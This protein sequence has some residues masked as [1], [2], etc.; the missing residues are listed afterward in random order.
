ME[1][2]LHNKLKDPTSAPAFDHS[3]N[4]RCEP[5]RA[6]NSAAKKLLY[7][8]HYSVERSVDIDLDQVN[9]ELEIANHGKWASYNNDVKGK[10]GAGLSTYWNARMLRNF[11][12]DSEFGFGETLDYM[13]Q[14]GRENEVV[15][16]LVPPSSLTQTPLFDEVP[17]LVSLVER[18]VTIDMCDRIMISR[19]EHNQRINWHS[20]NYYE[21]TYSHAY[22]H[23]PL[24]TNVG[25]EML[26]YMDDKIH[27]QHYGV[28]EAWII[29]TQHNHAV[30]NK[31]NSEDRYHILVLANFE[32]KKFNEL[33]LD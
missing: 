4:P 10:R 25:T 14:I 13:E 26:V 1:V 12:P 11:V 27:R 32:D 21:K 22:L 16:G 23:I 29:N 7:V 17:Y 15:N 33:L 9:K 30:N 5:S 2:T 20:H 19:I 3:C 8:P 6:T 31:I 18:F 24:K 28:G